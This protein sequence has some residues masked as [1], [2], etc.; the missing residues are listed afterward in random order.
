MNE[1]HHMERLQYYTAMKQQ[2]FNEAAPGLIDINDKL[3]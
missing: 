2:L 3:T 1:T